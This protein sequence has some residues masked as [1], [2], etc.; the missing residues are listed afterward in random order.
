[1]VEEDQYSDAA[2][3][4]LWTNFLKSFKYDNRYIYFETLQ[5]MSQR[6][7]KTLYVNYEHLADP[8]GIEDNKDQFFLL[9]KMTTFNTDLARDTLK[10]SAFE[11]LKEVDLE[12]ADS[13]VKEFRAEFMGAPI[14]KKMT[15]IRVDD[16][17]KFIK[18]SGV[19]QEYD[20]KPRQ[21]VRVI[22][23]RCPDN[24]LTEGGVDPPKRCSEKGCGAAHLEV[25]EKLSKVED[26]IR[27]TLQ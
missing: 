5:R 1:M 24:H 23:W 4:D 18:T 6:N 7:R 10:T 27:F 22:V 8:F 9:R 26:Y 20:A 15:D 11:L 13:I 17:G 2:I 21:A 19:V 25:D 3:V 16:M 14:E 12:Y